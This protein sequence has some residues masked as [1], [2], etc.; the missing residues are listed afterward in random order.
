MFVVDMGILEYIYT[1]GDND[2]CIYKSFKKKNIYDNNNEER[3]YNTKKKRRE[4][5]KKTSKKRGKIADI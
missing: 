4:R 3:K 2:L 5:K 1:L